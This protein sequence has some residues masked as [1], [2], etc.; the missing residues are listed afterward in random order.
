[1]RKLPVFKVAEMDYLYSVICESKTETFHEEGMPLQIS[2]FTPFKNDLL[3]KV[4][5]YQH[6][7]NERGRK[8]G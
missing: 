2:S 1:M 7:L 3:N 4:T 5:K 6:V 8:N